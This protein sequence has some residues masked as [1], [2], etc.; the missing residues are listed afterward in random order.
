MRLFL[1]AL[2]AFVIGALAALG[3]YRAVVPFPNDALARA[4]AFEPENRDWFFQNASEVFP[5]RTVARGGPAQPFEAVEGALDGFTFEYEGRARTLEDMYTDMETAGLIILHEGRILHESYGRGAGPGTRFT[6]FSLVKS[7]TSTLVGAAVQ[8]GLIGD[9]DDPL[10]KYL[11]ELEGT[12]YDGVTIRHAMQMS[13]GVAFDK[14]GWPDARDTVEFITDTAVIGKRRAFDMAAAYPRAAEP[15]TKF[16]YNT[17]ESQILLEL[18]RRVSGETAA[19]YM[20]RKVWRPLGM[21]HDAGWILD[22]PGQDGAEIGG[23]FFNASLRDWARFGQFIEQDGV[24]N[25]EQILPADW[26]ARAT[27]SD[28]PHLM[29]GEVHP[30][31][32][33]GYAWHWWTIADGG[34]TASGANGQTLYIHQDQDLVVARA[35]AWPEGWVA[36]YDAQSLALF[37]AL[38]EWL[39][40]PIE[41]A[42]A[43]EVVL[44]E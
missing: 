15:G 29:H 19:A 33:R 13:S 44:A 12:A 3:A 7:F 27:V 17:A 9:V 31:E 28:E 41:T 18:V 21:A 24:W 23:A 32:Q 2:A 26:V 39:D 5:T 16:N 43:E 34:F 20:E 37:R 25:G 30:N 42:S 14:E 6:T 4:N 1:I 22:A 38:G 10:T 8:D 35:S 11:P 40:E 36:E